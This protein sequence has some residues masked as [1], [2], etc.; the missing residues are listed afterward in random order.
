[1]FDFISNYCL[2][3]FTENQFQVQLD[4]FSSLSVF[5]LLF[6]IDFDHILSS[7]NVPPK[8]KLVSLTAYSRIH[9]PPKLRFC[10]HAAESSL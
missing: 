6:L 9:V 7:L 10:S 1:M 8:L 3:S 5:V 4:F 2:D